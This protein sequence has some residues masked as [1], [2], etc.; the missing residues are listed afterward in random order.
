MKGKCWS[1]RDRQL[2]SCENSSDDLVPLLLLVT[3]MAI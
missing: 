3:M 2:A 1:T